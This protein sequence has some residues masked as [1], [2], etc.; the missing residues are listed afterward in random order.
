[1][2]A[3]PPATRSAQRR[4]LA[5]LGRDAIFSVAADEGL[6]GMAPGQR[7]PPGAAGCAAGRLGWPLCVSLGQAG[8]DW[9]A[10]RP[11]GLGVP[12]AWR[13]S[14]LGAKAV[15]WVFLTPFF[16]VTFHRQSAEV[17]TKTS[18]FCRIFLP[19]FFDLLLSPAIENRSTFLVHY[20]KQV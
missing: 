5:A 2:R 9:R 3:F 11:A 8:K 19:L 12:S 15:G 16:P 18:K 10:R 13:P 7:P 20:D 17:C 1:M 14:C 6:G 4:L